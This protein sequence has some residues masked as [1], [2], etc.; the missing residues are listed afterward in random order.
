TFVVTGNLESLGRDDVEDLIKNYG[1][2]ITKAVSGKTSYLVVGDDPGPSKLEKAKKNK[3]W[4]LHEDDLL[5]LLRAS[6]PGGAASTQA[7][8]EPEPIVEE[9][10]PVMKSEPVVKAEPAEKHQPASSAAKSK[11][12]ERASHPIPAANRASIAPG[13]QLWTDKY[14]PK[15]LDELCGHRTQAENLIKWL[16][17][18]ATGKIPDPRAVLI[19]G[20]P[21][22][23]KT[24]VANLASEL[25][26]FDVLELNASDQRNKK[27]LQ[28]VLS[29]AIG[30]RSILEFDRNALSKLE[31]ERD[32][33]NGKG[34][35]AGGQSGE[36]KLVI[37]MD[38]VDGMSGGDRGGNAELIQMIKRTRVPIICICN[39][40]S[41]PKVR[42]LANS[43]YDLKFQ[44]PRADQM[45]GRMMTIA[46]NENLKL[47]ENALRQL[48]EST[49]NDIRQIINLMSS[50]AL[51]SSSMSYLDSKAFS[52]VNKKE[53]AVGPF[54][55][56]GKYLNGGVNMGMS[57]ADK[58]DLYY[59]DFSIIPLFVQE[60]YI[61]NT[62]NAARTGSNN[63]PAAE[64]ATLECLAEASDYISQADVVDSKIRG[65]QQWGLMPLHSVMSCVGPAYHM[66]GSHNGMYRFPGWLGQNSKGNKTSRLLR[67]IQS[68]MRLRVSVDKTELRKSYIPAMVPELTRPLIDNQIEGADAVIGVMDHYYLNKDNWDAMLELHL[69]GV[70]ILKQIPSTV[71]SAF[72]REYNKR[73]HPI[74]FQSSVG[75]SAAKAAMK[76]AAIRPDDE[77]V[78]DDDMME[79]DDD[80]D[81]GSDDDVGND[82]LIKAPKAKAKRKTPTGG[83]GK[84]APSKRRAPA[85][86][87]A[88][89]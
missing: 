62:P 87:R 39:D 21:G 44:R 29:P 68:N 33:L 11:G 2:R 48:V 74:A 76:A 20:P 27:S 71:K 59:N 75:A 32:Q 60:N 45:K 19:S 63:K 34:K 80:E 50:Y 79:V 86:P 17:V 55:I 47:D 77:G 65:S 37:V 5:E 66:R 51:K 14:K 43:C 42:S 81:G 23:G 36:K 64:L 61:D 16:N 58:I 31:D 69:G 1:G 82:K 40:R 52:S 35:F 72:T 57:F 49:Q 15:T 22:I 9:E 25:A 28:E 26:G 18:W 53:V 3:T 88:R 6:N 10:A 84:A 13:S 89:K 85:K 8:D 7:A 38:E 67:E 73:T 12:K 41:S 24:T 30:N 4:C 46:R 78:V 83:S 56:I 54:D 70:D